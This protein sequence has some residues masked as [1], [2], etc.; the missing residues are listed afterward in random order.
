VL[1]SI[2]RNF[3]AGM[4]GGVAL[5]AVGADLTTVNTEMVELADPDEDDRRLLFGLLVDHARLTGSRKAAD[6]LRQTGTAFRQFRKVV[7]KRSPT[8]GVTA[9]TMEARVS[10][11]GGRIRASA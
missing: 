3:G 5:L 6:L 10:G 1:G 2:G 4:S 11:A 7:P 9:E 8:V